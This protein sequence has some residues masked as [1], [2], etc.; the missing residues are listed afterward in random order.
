VVVSE[1]VEHTVQQQDLNL[2][3]EFM[4]VSAGLISRS[5]DA[6]C[7]IAQFACW[8]GRR[9]AEHIGRP[10]YSAK[11]AIQASQF[12]V[13]RQQAAEAPPARNAF[14]NEFRECGQGPPRQ[15]SR[16]CFKEDQRF[17]RTLV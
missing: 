7:D 6:D 10:V 11:L 2:G 15:G 5:F 14:R 8:R 17:A 9:E 13:S 1:Q 4:A 3:A 16:S 12:G